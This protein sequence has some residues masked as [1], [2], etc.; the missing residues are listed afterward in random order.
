MA[1]TKDFKVKNGIQPT[2]Y[3]EG[4]GTV[5]SG[6]SGYNLAGASYDSV[7]FSTT[8]QEASPFGFTFKSDGTKL[9][10]VGTTSDSVYQYSLSTA[11]DISTAS[12]ESKSLNVSSQD[13][14][15]YQ[16]KLSSDGTKA[17]I[18]GGTN[19][20]VYQY[21][22]S[23]AFDISTGS[24]DS[25][26][27]SLTGQVASGL[28]YGLF[29]K[30]DGTKMY[31]TDIGSDII[32]QYALST[33]F[34][35]STAS[36]DNKSIDVTTEDTIPSN[37]AFN[38][39]GTKMYVAGD[40]NNSIF[41]YTLSTAWDVST[42][43]YD[44][45]SFDVSSQTSLVTCIEFNNDGTKL[46]VINT[47][48]D[49]LYQYSTTQSTATL[50]LSTGS[51]FEITPTSDIEINLSNP[52][53]SGTVSQATLLLEG[54]AKTPYDIDNASYDNKSFSVASQETYPYSVE[55]KSDGT[56]MYVIGNTNDTLYQY[57]LSTAWDVSTAS[58]DSVSFST[59]SQA[60]IPIGLHFK[61]DG[62]KFYVTN[63]NDDNVYQYNL[64]TAW[65]ISTASYDN[66]SFLY[67]S[68]SVQGREVYF[69]TDG[70]KM[71][72]L[73]DSNETV[74]QYSLSIA[75]DVSTASY[76]SVSFSVSSQDTTP[77][78]LAFNSDGTKMF[79]VGQQNDNVYQYSLSTDWDIST[80]SYDSISFSVQSQETDPN[81]IAFKPDGTKFYIIGNVSDTVYQY[82]SAISA[83]ITYPSTLEF[84]G[85]TAP[86][87]PAIGETDV[88]T[89]TT[90]DGGT[91]YQAVQAIDGAK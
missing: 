80:A 77:F 19:T 88:L 20:T 9:Y 91:S 82:S 67:S 14:T 52:A 58:Y 23:T 34:N 24:Y 15:P 66:K 27:F 59:S 65:D 47:G 33:G 35:L 46:Y 10:I 69:K 75:W 26:S 13:A 12:Y 68:Q 72:L 8:S 11:F 29:F 56:K 1:N 43:S 55:F 64:S 81:H 6:T 37:L 84:A 21:S 63:N 4:V 60:T 79:V 45:V 57:S 53:D 28:G 62:T 87:S 50:D 89:F 48:N 42:A 51:V 40:A 70:T 16:I 86:T 32:Y 44:S 85:G 39:D 36:Y 90:T 71:Y 22:L 2:V 61:P 76:D 73:E 5:T 3:Y 74:Y 54:G 38:N 83:T 41:Q 31:V 17:F 49:T 30:T 78:G 25:V 7:S 18:L